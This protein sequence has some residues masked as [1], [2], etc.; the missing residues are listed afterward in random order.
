MSNERVGSFREE[1]LLLVLIYE[2]VGLRGSTGT[3]RSPLNITEDSN[4]NLIEGRVVVEE[5]VVAC[6]FK[7][8]L[9]LN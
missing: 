7:V 2:L 3:C 4:K 9:T 1:E 6:I 5:I 8:F